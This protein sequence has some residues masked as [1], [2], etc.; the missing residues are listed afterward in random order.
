MIQPFED[1]LL[2][3]L[4]TRQRVAWILVLLALTAAVGMADLWMRLQY[5]VNLYPFP[6]ILSVLLFGDSGLVAVLV[7]LLL[8]H[9]IQV[10]LQLESHTILIN[11]LAQLGL[12]SGV[13]FLCARLVQAYRTLYQREQ[14][15]SRAR[16]AVLVSLTHEIR[17][18]LFAL[19]GILDGLLRAGRRKGDAALEAPLEA[20]LEAIRGVNRQV[21]DLTQALR[22][23]LQGFTSRLEPQDL[24]AL[25][26]KV[27]GRYTPEVATGHSVEVEIG[28]DL[29]EIP[30]DGS[31][32][33]RTVDN[34]LSNAVRYAHPGRIL[35]TARRSR[36]Q[37]EIAV[38]DEGP[39]IPPQDRERVFRRYD[40][41]SHPSSVPGLGVG[42]YLARLY[43]EAQ[44][45]T[46]ALDPCCPGARVVVSLPCGEPDE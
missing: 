9:W 21:N 6:V 2:G 40:R 8:Y 36:E 45:G 22:S 3:R 41:G 20:A 28:P 16:Q 19:Q 43:T 42:L 37:V 35:L 12:T 11:N 27:A 5:H 46:V 25:L 32:V 4:T 29:E 14:E 33:D 17:N 34:L 7:L 31:L 15:V 44:G 39:G 30:C 23:D 10:D 18:P 24:G 38:E 13:G 26:R 1:L